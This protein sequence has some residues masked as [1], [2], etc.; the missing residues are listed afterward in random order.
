MATKQPRNMPWATIGAA[1]RGG[2]GFRDPMRDQ[3]RRTLGM[4]RTSSARPVDYLAQ[5]GA[6]WDVPGPVQYRNSYAR[7]WRSSARPML[8]PQ[9]AAGVSTGARHGHGERVG[10]C[11]LCTISRHSQTATAAKTGVAWRK[12]VYRGPINCE[13]DTNPRSAVR[14]SVS[15]TRAAIHVAAILRWCGLRVANLVGNRK[16]GV[17]GASSLAAAT[18]PTRH[19]EFG[20][21]ATRG[22]VQRVR[23]VSGEKQFFEVAASTLKAQRRR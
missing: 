2:V 8:W 22:Y 4:W 23:L 20:L 11:N 14:N 15:S 6:E 17:G 21:D 5:H 3:R 13:Y 19:G 16:L 10:N 12:S 7:R 9:C 1:A 18:W